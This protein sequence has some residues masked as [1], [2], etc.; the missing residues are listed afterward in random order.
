[1]ISMNAVPSPEIST[2][3]PE[4]KLQVLHSF[5]DAESFTQAWNA[6]VLHTG[7]DVYQTFDWCSLWW[8]YYGKRRQ[9]HLLLFFSGKELVGLIPTFI[10]TVWLGFTFVRTAKII[11]SDFSLQLCNLPVSPS[12]LRPALR[13]ATEYLLNQKKCDVFLLGPLAGPS[14]QFDE[15]FSVCSEPSPFV[16]S[17]KLLGRSCNTY[18]FLPPNYEEYIK[19]VGKQQRGNFNRS[20][21][22]LEKSHVV[23][24]DEI[25]TP[26]KLQ[27][28]FQTFCQL[29]DA[30]WQAEGKLGH[31]GSWPS[32]RDFNRDLINTLG[33]QGMVRF[34]RILADDKV[35]SSQYSFVFGHTNYWRLPAR[36][37]GSTW[38][39]LSFG[40]M[41]LVKMIEA[42]I[43]DGRRTIEGGRGHYAY[44]VQLGGCEVPS[45]RIQITR[46]GL[47]ISIRLAIF[48]FLAALLDVTYY[49]L[50]YMRLAPR[51]RIFRSPIWSIWI[52]STW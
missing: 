13:C 2:P 11:G 27:S 3:E 48:K 29:H 40:K 50:I 10:E 34:Y 17:A 28:E 32:A 47:G 39:R 7:A 37:H 46:R 20:V 42:S 43:K 1:M 22:Q 26:E 25:S 45:R 35:V 24:V 52:R 9:L 19:A 6:L 5:S 14:S 30:Q 23:S 18:F 33:T 15:L 38:D 49:K 16:Q 12:A 4:L 41:G 31:F 21:T 44:K 51:Y 36:V 8:K